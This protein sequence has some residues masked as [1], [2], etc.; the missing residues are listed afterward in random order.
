MPNKPGVQ[1]SV[2]AHPQVDK[3]NELL[4]NNVSYNGIVTRYPTLSR[5][6]ICRHKTA[7]L[8]EM[9]IRAQAAKE[10]SQTAQV[11]NLF[12]QVRTLQIKA[13]G[14]LQQAETM[15]DLKTAV[16]AIREARA[17]LE[18]LG[19]V[20]GELQPEKIMIQLEIGRAHV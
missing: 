19:K 4:V 16:S 20:S 8:S 3:I 11:D 10:T 6:S 13:L 9:L 2:C 14:I 7:H 12:S 15:G 1:C 18:L 5:M 17:C